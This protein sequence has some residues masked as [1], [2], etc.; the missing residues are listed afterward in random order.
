MHFTKPPIHIRGCGR[1]GTTLLLSILSSHPEIF[2]CPLE[3]GMYDKVVQDKSRKLAPT[4]LDRLYRIL[5][6][7]RIKSTNT[8]WCEKSP[9]NINHVQEISSYHEG[10]F[11]FIHIVRDGRDVILSKH[12]TT[13]DEYYVALERWVHDVKAGYEERNNSLVY[14][15]K[16]EDLILQFESEIV[17]ICDFLEIPMCDDIL[18]WNSHAS[19]RKNGAYFGEIKSIFKT[20][21]GK[22]QKPENRQRA[23]ELMKLEG[24]AELLSYYNY[25]I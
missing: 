20:S 21:V 15:V 8:R 4:R 13:P 3:L 17:G 24:A 7:K 10:R 11:K 2:A 25:E 22:W 12:P 18:N 9:T 1:S 23:E 16:Y 6:T 19:V 14:T 5:I